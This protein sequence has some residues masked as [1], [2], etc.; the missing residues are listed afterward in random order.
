MATLVMKFGGSLTADARHISRVAQVI[1]AES[2]AWLRMVVVVSAMAGA[3]DVLMR[4]ADQAATRDAAGYRRTVAQLRADHL[5]VIKALFDDESQRHDLVARIDRVLFDVLN[6]CDSVMGRREA[7]PRDRD[8]ILAAGERMMLHILAALVRQ[9]GLNA[10]LIDAASLI[11]T[12]DRHLSANPL[13][14]I[15]DERV[16]QVIRPL[17]DAGVVPL[18]TGFIG[19]PRTGAPPPLGRGGSDYTAPLP[20]ASLPADQAS[21]CTHT[22]RC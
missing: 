12:D 4:A 13:I 19:V 2:L 15:I 8:A 11:V 22:S 14:D 21:A 1:S 17:L 16:E 7:L 10:A 6:N 18:V 9:E 20:A 5:T 3:T